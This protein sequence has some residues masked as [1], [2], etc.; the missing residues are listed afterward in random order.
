MDSGNIMERKEKASSKCAFPAHND[1]IL[2][3]CLKQMFSTADENQ[4]I[5]TLL[6][7]IGLTFDCDRVYIFENKDADKVCNTYEWCASGIAPQKNLLQNAPSAGVAFWFE[8]F[9]K[10]GSL[11]IPDIESIRQTFPLTY[12]ILKPQDIHSLIAGP[13]PGKKH[14]VGFIGAD[15]PNKQRVNQLSDLL[16]VIGYF[17]SVLLKRRDL[18]DK[19][20][21][22]SFFDP[23]T[24]ALNRA[25]LDN[26]FSSHIDSHSIGLVYG[27]ISGLKQVNDA[28]G[29]AAGDE[30]IMECY[31]QLSTSMEGDPVFRIGGDEFVVVC[32]DLTQTE[33]NHKVEKLKQ[34]IA[35][36][37]YH[38]A[39]GSVWTDVLPSS[40]DGLLKLAD[41]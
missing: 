17:V 35:F 31:R 38:L 20:K 12:A 29:H 9:D 22:Q 6:R 21:K 30:L 13:I 28:Y 5:D 24:G 16:R 3:E 23:M 26:F 19:L 37:A 27:D 4:A 41:K 33:F 15:N 40:F 25:A 32:L 11:C 10:E 1:R 14:Y 39:I 2:S 7:F 36:E 18:T 8:M 34:V